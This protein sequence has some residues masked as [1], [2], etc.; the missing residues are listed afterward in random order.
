MTEVRNARVYRSVAPDADDGAQAL[1]AKDVP[2]PISVAEA[3]SA[4]DMA[5]SKIEALESARAESPPERLAAIDRRLSQWRE[6]LAELEW[7]GERLRAG[8]SSPSIELARAKVEI[9][10]LQKKVR[11]LELRPMLAMAPAETPAMKNALREAQD[12]VRKRDVTITNLRTQ[13]E[14]ATRPRAPAPPVVPIS[15]ETRRMYVERQHEAAAETLEVIDEMVAHGATVTPL[16]GVVGHKLTAGLP[17]GY[18]ALW[19]VSKLPL[20]V[21]AAAELAMCAEGATG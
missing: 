21:A 20:L 9:E 14:Q 13:L 12:A 6:K 17:Q 7:A 5:A 19:R 8:E 1:R 3:D 16:C 18:R 4:C 2:W 11:A 15:A 10:T